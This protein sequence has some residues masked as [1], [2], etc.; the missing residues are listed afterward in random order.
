[1]IVHP[2]Y[3]INFGTFQSFTD[4]MGHGR[5][6]RLFVG[7]LSWHYIHGLS[8]SFR[9]EGLVS[10]A[11]YQRADFLKTGFGYEDWHWNLELVSQGV[12][13]VTAKKTALFYRRKS[14]SMFTAWSRQA[15]LFGRANFLIIQ[16]NGRNLSEGTTRVGRAG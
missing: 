13:H 5:S 16:C 11:P 12:R 6:K 8:C 9:R 10:S 15:W 7:K 1:M 3:V 14:V 2:E 4:S